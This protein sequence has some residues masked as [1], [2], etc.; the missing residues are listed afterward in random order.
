MET[1]EIRKHPILDIHCTSDGQVIRTY[2]KRKDA[3]A[4]TYGYMSGG[5]LVVRI[6]SKQV[7]VHRLIAETFLPNNENKPT[8]DHINRNKTDNRVENL[9]WADV[10]EQADNR[11]FVMERHEVETR[12]KDNLAVYTRERRKF[13]RTTGHGYGRTVPI[14][15]E[16]H[17]KARE[18]QARYRKRHPDRIKQSNHTLYIKRRSTCSQQ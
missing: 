9:R 14:N 16:A 3:R 11:D 6:G 17:I 4:P 18:R 5:Y 8:V 7:S 15:D 12:E 10:V 1:P 13:V 2:S